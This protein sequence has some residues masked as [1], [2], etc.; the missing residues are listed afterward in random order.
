MLERAERS[1]DVW[2]RGFALIW[3]GWSFLMKGQLNEGLQ[4]GQEALAIFEKLEEPFGT[5]VASGVILAAI[6]MATGDIDA[7]KAYCLRGMQAAEEI[8]YRRLLQRT[9]DGLGMA[10]LLEHDFQQAEQFFI[11]SLR[12]SQECGQTREMLSSLLDLASVYH[13]QGNLN[14]ALGLIAIVSNHPASD[15]NSL[16]RPGFLR[17]DAEKLRVQ[18]ETQLDPS[19][20]L[21]AWGAGQKQKLADVVTKIL[22]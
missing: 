22:S 18:I 12:I 8:N 9:Y 14:D 3:S 7:A 11:K 1:G 4:P 10:S 5:S 13:A 17:D 20:Y 21:S 19:L 6:A 15:Q 16:N 2:E